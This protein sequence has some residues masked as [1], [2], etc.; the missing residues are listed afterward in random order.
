[1]DL[2]ARRVPSRQEIITRQVGCDHGIDHPE[3]VGQKIPAGKGE[4]H[5]EQEGWG[6][7]GAGWPGIFIFMP[8]FPDMAPL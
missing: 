8:I 2:R 5:P 6:Q 1:M 7:G 4:K 3:Q